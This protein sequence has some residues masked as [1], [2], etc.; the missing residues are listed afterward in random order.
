LVQSAVDPGD[1]PWRATC[2]A[3]TS[4][5]WTELCFGAIELDAR[6]LATAGDHAGAVA[7][8]QALRTRCEEFGYHPGLEEA[9]YW[10]DAS[11]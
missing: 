8:W 11:P 1:R 10:L 6:R 9:V 5:V 7:Q 3:A 2:N 4:A